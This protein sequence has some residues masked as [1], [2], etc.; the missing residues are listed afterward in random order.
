MDHLDVIRKE[1][2]RVVLS[3]QDTLNTVEPLGIPL[4]LLSV[5][6]FPVFLWGVLKTTV[7]MA[8]LLIQA[9]FSSLWLSIRIWVD[10][11]NINLWY[12]SKICQKMSE[13]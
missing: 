1:R 11:I 5:V 2:D 10:V 3:M 7:V 13:K 6:A 12:L 4:W 8:V 9:I